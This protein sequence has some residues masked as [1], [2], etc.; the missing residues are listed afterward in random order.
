LKHGLEATFIN[1][2]QQQRELFRCS[3]I[4][5]Y[6]RY[7]DKVRESFAQSQFYDDPYQG[8]VITSALSAAVTT[9]T[10]TVSGALS[11]RVELC[12]VS[13]DGLIA[14]QRGRFETVPNTRG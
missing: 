7:W 13:N 5:D 1:L 8:A 9:P 10:V 4:D 14:F 6:E 2:L 3:D 11:A 12:D